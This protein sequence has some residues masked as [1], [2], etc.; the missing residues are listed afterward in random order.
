MGL[1]DFVAEAGEKL[2]DKVLG[3]TS[4]SG[5]TEKAEVSADRIDKLREE[6]INTSLAANNRSS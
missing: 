2:T 3:D 1:F 4:G 6:S 5:I